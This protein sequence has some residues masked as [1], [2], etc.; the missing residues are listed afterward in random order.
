MAS[1]VHVVKRSSLSLQKQ[2]AL[3]GQLFPQ[4]RGSVRNGRLRWCCEVSPSPLS[5]QYLIELEYSWSGIPRVYVS[6]GELLGLES[7]D[8]VPHQY[9]N[10][11][12]ESRICV[13]LNRLPW[14]SSTVIAKTLIPWA[15]EWIAHF[16]VWLVSG[17]WTGSGIHNGKIET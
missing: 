17:E 12:T 16:E 10:R 3:L 13:C 8:A 4:G 5:L 1:R 2:L 15:V 11:T 14:D 9:P 6:K 7:S